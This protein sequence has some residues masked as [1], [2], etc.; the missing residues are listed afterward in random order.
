MAVRFYGDFA[1]DIGIQ[2]RINIYDNDFSAA[3]E[4]VV[5]GVPGF[6]LTY[7]GNNQEEF[8]PILASRC[9]FTLYNEGGNFQAWLNSI[10]PASEEGRFP[11]EVLTDP[12]TVDEAVFWRGL[13]L[14]EQLQIMDE[15][16]PS[17]VNFTAADDLVQLKETT[18]D[19]ISGITTTS[20]VTEQIIEMLKLTRSSD[21]WGSS[22]I[23]FRYAND[24]VTD[25]FTTGDFI[26]SIG[27]YA[28][29]IPGTSPLEYHNA[30][31]I[32]RSI[33]ISFNAR[34]FQA[35][36]IW[37]FLPIN[38]YERRSL[39]GVDY[40]DLHQYDKT[41]TEVTWTLL[42]R[43]QWISNQLIT[44]T[45]TNRLD[46]MAGNTI[47]YSRPVKR[48]SRTRVHRG[49]EFLFQYNTGF[50]TLSSTANDIELAD[51]DRTYFSGSTHLITLNYNID[52]AAVASDNNFINF[53]TVRADF[54][55]KF[56]DQ[57]Y[58]DTGW[59]GTAGTKKV[60]IGTYY[61]SAGFENVGQIS[62]Q[63]E[64]LV[65]DEVGLDVTLNVEVLNGAGG[66]IVSTL[67]SHDV[68]FIL[69]VYPGD[70]NEGVGD[71]VVFSS[72]TTL[73]NQVRLSQENVITGNVGID[74][75]AGG[76]QIPVYSGAFY[77]VIGSDMDE[78]VSSLTTTAYTL[79]RLG[80]REILEFTQ[81]PHRI[82]QGTYYVNSGFLWP[83]HLI[84][85]T[86]DYVMHEM[87]YNANDS[88]ATV[89]RW[90]L[91]PST[92]NL[93][94]RTNE[95]KSNNPRDRFAPDSN[96]YADTIATNFDDL[97]TGSVPQFVAVQLIEHSSSSTHTIDADD[98]NGFMY[99]N[100]YVDTA[101][102]TGV[103]FLPKV[104]D[105][106][107]RMFRFKSDDTISATKNYRVGIATT[108]YSNGVRID[109]A[110]YFEMNRSY[111]GIAV[112]CYDGQ[113]YV[114]QRKQK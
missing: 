95:V 71:E 30:F 51:D 112:L 46:K 44:T 67:P 20:T 45:G 50:T 21:L 5:V 103:I 81:L 64:E 12:G 27:M 89:E 70:G 10:V 90:E 60:V 92:A 24:F 39:G 35:E 49:N 84:R 29:T 106:E 72:E 6:S 88:E 82:R 34:L 36:G 52:I 108:E 78:W 114:I 11:I 66:S 33:C 48:V 111:D 69:R 22:D 76:S 102:G 77:G 40:D 97:L 61:K 104:A 16:L 3:S 17:A 43:T 105:N 107:G 74:Y 2:F 62:V 57:Y 85:D 110:S 58:T 9:D 80:V 32:L 113:W 59:S 83:Y 55:I 68:L 94:F 109:G 28:P 14:P 7:E 101:N 53:H 100:T 15:P 8:Q 96:A 13:L 65:D 79:H 37:H 73:N 41:G 42:D 47:E 75:A 63:V 56:G 26:G 19:D 38:K 99:M 31:D 1:N 54:T 93:A 86:E 4:E 18:Y 91:N 98:D 25:G 23:Y 87:T